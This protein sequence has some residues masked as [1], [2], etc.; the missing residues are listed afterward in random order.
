MTTMQLKARRTLAAGVTLLLLS[1]GGGGST[2]PSTPPPP[3]P[4][5]PPT[6]PWEVTLSS[7]NS[8]DLGL[9]LSVGGGPVDSITVPSGSIVIGEGASSRRVLLR[10]SFSSGLIA[11]V[12]VPTSST[13]SYS[14]QL[15][16]VAGPDYAQRDVDAYG[17]TTRR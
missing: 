17:V 9:L 10:G 6:G 3:P 2:G 13:G 7:P 15:L 11:R 16:Q 14:A 8:G 5:P 1:C 4:P 12:W